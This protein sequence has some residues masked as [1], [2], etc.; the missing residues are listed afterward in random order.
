MIKRGTLVSQLVH[1]FIDDPDVQVYVRNYL[2]EHVFETDPTGDE[3]HPLY[4][5]WYNE[6]S[7]ELKRLLRDVSDH[8]VD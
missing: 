4:E 7:N 1:K 2:L 8:L 6:Y 5:D 3:S